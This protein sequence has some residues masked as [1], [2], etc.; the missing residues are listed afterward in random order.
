MIPAKINLSLDSFIQ[1]FKESINVKPEVQQSIRIQAFLHTDIDNL[2]TL[3]ILFLNDKMNRE[4]PIKNSIDKMRTMIKY[5]RY[6]NK[7]QKMEIQKMEIQNMI[8]AE[9]EGY[10]KFLEDLKKSKQQE[11]K[12]IVLSAPASL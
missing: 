2:K 11:N 9:L 10:K 6:T 5:Y 3:I 7:L 1:K 12:S 4:M 8:E